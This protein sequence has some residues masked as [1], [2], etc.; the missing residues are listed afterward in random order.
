[1]AVV[2]VKSADILIDVSAS[3]DLDADK[4]RVYGVLKDLNVGA[5]LSA[6]IGLPRVGLDAALHVMDSLLRAGGLPGPDLFFAETSFLPEPVRDGD[7]F[8]DFVWVQVR[9]PDDSQQRETYERVKHAY[10]WLYP[11]LHDSHLTIYHVPGFFQKTQ[12]MTMRWSVYD[13][14]ST[15]SSTTLVIDAELAKAREAMQSRTEPTTSWLPVPGD[16]GGPN[17]TWCGVRDLPLVK[18]P[19]QEHGVT[20]E[21][22]LEERVALFHDLFHTEGLPS[23]GVSYLVCVPLVGGAAAASVWDEEPALGGLGALFVIAGYRG[24]PR[25]ELPRELLTRIGRSL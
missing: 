18:G 20:E 19:R 24:A 1:M 4:T 15:A 23:F 16:P 14:K 17:C 2:S 11:A 6:E 13:K 12:R 10:E 3:V 21:S 7:R 22:K 8:R 25:S 9:G 5:A